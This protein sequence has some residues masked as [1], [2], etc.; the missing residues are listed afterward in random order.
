MLGIN[1]KHFHSDWKVNKTEEV[2]NFFT[3]H[4]RLYNP[5]K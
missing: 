3:Q 5:D 2:A 4:G 1:A